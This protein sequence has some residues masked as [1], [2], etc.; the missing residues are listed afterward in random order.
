METPNLFENVPKDLPEELLQT[1]GGNEAVRIERIVSRGH[2]SEPGFWY[3]QKT[4]EFVILLQ[5]K[6]RLAF[7]G[8]TVE[9]APGDYLIIEPHQKHRVEWTDPEQASFWLAVH[10]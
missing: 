9:L 1:L 2:R 8:H 5:G 4:H 7:E 10:Y 3:D 6:A